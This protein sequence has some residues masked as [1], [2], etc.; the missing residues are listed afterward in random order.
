M[1]YAFH[2]ALA[3]FHY[4]ADASCLEPLLLRRWCHLLRWG[5]IKSADI[6]QSLMLLFVGLPRHWR[7]RCFEVGIALPTCLPLHTFRLHA[8]YCCHHASLSLLLFFVTEPFR[9]YLRSLFSLYSFAT[10]PSYNIFTHIVRWFTILLSYFRWPPFR[11]LRYQVALFFFFTDYASLAFRFAYCFFHYHTPIIRC[12]ITAGWSAHRFSLQYLSSS[13]TIFPQCH[14]FI[15]S[16]LLHHCPALLPSP[17][18][19]SSCFTRLIHCHSSSFSR[20][21]ISSFVILAL[22]ESAV[23]VC[24]KTQRWLSC[25]AFKAFSSSLILRL[26][27]HH[28]FISSLAALFIHVVYTY[29]L[30]HF[31]IS[32]LISPSFSSFISFRLLP[33]F[34]LPS[35]IYSSFSATTIYLPTMLIIFVLFH[36]FIYYIRLQ[37]FFSLLVSYYSLTFSSA[38]IYVLFFADVT[39]LPC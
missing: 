22:P 38:F 8:N 2:V 1:P 37:V 29:W 33:S 39:M 32:P 17:H 27:R 10:P 5:G 34:C 16:H 15:S 30:L 9:H 12:H 4:D 24:A 31:I 26:I 19:L 18:C 21:A 25:C 20:L 6:R 14:S 36:T 35:G 7:Y 23:Q 28:Y 11:L 3:L 13:L